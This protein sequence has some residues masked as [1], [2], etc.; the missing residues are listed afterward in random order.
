MILLE[1]STITTPPEHLDLS[2]PQSKNVCKKKKKKGVGTKNIDVAFTQKVQ[3]S[4]MVG[5]MISREV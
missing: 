4:K 2:V 5:L 1:A 3:M